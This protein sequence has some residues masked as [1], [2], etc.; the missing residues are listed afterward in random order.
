MLALRSTSVGHSL[1]LS[2]GSLSTSGQVG[3]KP[4]G[5]GLQTPV[6]PAATPS[7]GIPRQAWGGHAQSCLLS[8]APQDAIEAV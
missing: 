3:V 5:L 8:L 4:E 6:L 2:K 1:R 7:A